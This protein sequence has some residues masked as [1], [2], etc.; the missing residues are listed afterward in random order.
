MEQI[1]TPLTIILDPQRANEYLTEHGL[2]EGFVRIDAVLIQN[3]G[4]SGG[5]PCAIIAMV[6]EQGR[7]F[8]AKTTLRLFVSAARAMHARH[9]DLL[10]GN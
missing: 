4:T 2:E 1:M 3:D 6:D 5:R 8:V 9:P 10:E 7:R